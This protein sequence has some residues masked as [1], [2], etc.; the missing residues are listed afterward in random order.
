MALLDLSTGEFR[1]F[2]AENRE[3]LETEV[4]RNEPREIL[5]Q[6]DFQRTPEFDSFKR[7]IGAGFVGVAICATV[8]ALVVTIA[9][10]YLERRLPLEEEFSLHIRMRGGGEN[11]DRIENLLRK[12]GYNVVASR[13]RVAR[14]KAQIDVT[15][16]ITSKD[17]ADLDELSGRLQQQLDGIEQ[18]TFER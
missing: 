18:I 9:F 7:A 13:L 10:K 11:V 15:F 4:A 6:E 12:S 2:Q 8:F 3:R 14:E 16:T 17:R 1:V 5:I